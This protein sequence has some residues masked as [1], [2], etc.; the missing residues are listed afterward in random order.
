VRRQRRQTPR[1]R[2]RRLTRQALG[3]PPQG[4]QE[5]RRAACLRWPAGSLRVTVT[6]SADILTTGAVQPP[7]AGPAAAAR[8]A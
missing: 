5:G 7:T 3:T 2:R 6:L 4:R 1:R 8:R